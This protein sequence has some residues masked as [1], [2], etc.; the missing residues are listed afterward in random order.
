[1]KNSSKANG[2]KGI[3]HDI[4]NSQISN[5]L[6]NFKMS[7]EMFQKRKIF[8][9]KT[10]LRKSNQNNFLNVSIVSQARKVFY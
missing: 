1:M 3:L 4:T 2:K 10:F 5:S 7:N 9:K 6:K 8:S